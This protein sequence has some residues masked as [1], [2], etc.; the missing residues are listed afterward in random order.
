MKN[1]Y[2]VIVIGSGHAGCEAA[3]ASAKMGQ[4]TCMLTMNLDSIAFLACNPSIGGTA[5]GQLAGEVTALGGA[6]GV[7]ADKTALQMR[8]LNAGKG[9]AVQS[10]RAQVDKNKYHIEMK[11]LLENTP[12]LYIIQA[13][14]KE[15]TSANGSV[16]SV[17]TS[18]GQ[19]F[20]AKSIIVC[21]GVY[22]SS[23]ITTGDMRLPSGP[24]G[25]ARAEFLSKSLEL[26]GHKLTRF[27]T[28]TPARVHGGTI[29]FSIM[30]KQE[31]DGNYS[32]SGERLS[33]KDD[34]PCYLTYT[35]ETTH[36]IIRDNIHLAPTYDGTIL[37]VGPRYCPSIE[38]KVER[39]S[40]K[41]RHQVFI[42]PEAKDT[43]EVY[44]QGMSTSFGADI[45]E[46]IYHSIKGLENAH[47]LRYAYA[48]EYDCIDPTTLT[49]SL[50]SKIVKGLF[51]AGQIN[52][53]SGYEEAAGQGLIAG[54]N[55]GLFNMKK[56]PFILGRDEAYIGVLIDD[57]ITMGV[58]EPYRM[59]TSRAEYR[60]ILRQDNCD[61]R[62][63]P[64][65]IKYNLASEKQ[66]EIYNQKLSDYNK[67][68]KELEKSFVPK[69]IFDLF[70]KNSE[71]QPQNRMSLKE[72][73]RRNNIDIFK[74][75]EY[76]NIFEDVSE[77][78]LQMV[79]TFV[80]YEGYIKMQNELIEKTNKAS[81]QVLPKD[82]D[83][84]SIEGLRLEARQKLQKI[85]PDNIGQASRISGVSPSDISVLLIVLHQLKK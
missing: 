58:D 55:A 27:K 64:Y 65:A 18:F 16:E 6:M 41:D 81:K 59:M 50:Q 84:L 76:F 39:F 2:D 31:S 29:D 15:I 70:E 7:I 38:T 74:C 62:L 80:K 53:T 48:I 1:N 20:F 4:K 77:N 54:V 23:T 25:F 35:N 10:L 42:E 30:E 37:G 67:C 44:I 78:I 56:P 33:T 75:K 14:A 26:L 12:N 85:R 71:K 32:F 49:T 45:Q 69:E 60:L 51:F 8:F 57:L 3:L 83:Y 40:D 24:S 22:L 17:I 68:I 61:F 82:I 63:T 19:Q 43:V 9:V 21:S 52:G 46:K 79:N 28:G 73:I 36:K 11:K 47:I 34:M 5:K 72:I 66:I 13:E